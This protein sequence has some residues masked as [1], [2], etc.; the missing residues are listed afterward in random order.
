MCYASTHVQPKMVD[1]SCVRWSSAMYILHHVGTDQRSA[2]FTITAVFCERC[3]R[4]G[5]PEMDRWYKLSSGAKGEV[6]R[7]N[8]RSAFKWNRRLSGPIL[9]S[10]LSASAKWTVTFEHGWRAHSAPLQ[11]LLHM[12]GPDT[13]PIWYEWM[14][15]IKKSQDEWGCNMGSMV[16]VE[17][18]SPCLRADGNDWPD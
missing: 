9:Q 14:V 17:G 10:V 7:I 8:R 12:K 11:C 4:G 5:V 3:W 15:A 6:N 18:W 2:D 16:A 1:T 13:G